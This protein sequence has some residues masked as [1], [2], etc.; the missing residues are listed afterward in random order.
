MVNQRSSS[1]NAY[2][3]SVVLSIISDYTGYFNKELHKILKDKFLSYDTSTKNLNTIE[4][5]KYLT[6]IRIWASSF[7]NLYI[8]LPNETKINKKKG[9]NE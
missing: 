5:E 3:N 2:Y 7:L 6:K 8:P 1:Q 4:F 9:E